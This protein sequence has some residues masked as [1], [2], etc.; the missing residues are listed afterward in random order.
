M[1]AWM[2]YAAALSAALCVAALAAERALRLTGGPTRLAWALAMAASLALPF[3]LPR[4]ADPPLAAVQPIVDPV[5]TDYA[6]G[7]PTVVS[8]EDPS[9][10][11]TESP[12]P[13]SAWT[14]IEAR[15]DGAMP[16]AWGAVSGALLI[17]LAAAGAVLARRRRGWEPAVVSGAAVLLSE[18][19]GPAVVG[20]VDPAIVLPRWTTEWA[21]PLRRLIVRHERE[22]VE[23]GDPRLLLGA[24]VAVAL[25][26]WNP[27]L[28]WQLRRL[29][30]AVEIDCDT[31]TLRREGD[32][33]AYGLLLLEVGR[34][35]AGAPLPVAAFSEPRSFLERRIRV[36]TSRTPR[37][38]AFRLAALALVCAGAA[39]GA[40]ALPA[41]ALPL[42]GGGSGDSAPS[43]DAALASAPGAMSGDTTLPILA[44]VQQLSR[45]IDAQYPPLLRGA[46][47]GGMATV[48]MR[49]AENGQPEDITVVSADRAELGQ[50]ALRAMASARF[51]PA[52]VEGRAVPYRLTL[53]VTFQPEGGD[54]PPAL[55]RGR[56]EADTV[57]VVA[58]ESVDE[59]PRIVNAEQ[60]ARTFERLYPPML[61]EA[62]ISGQV[63]VRLLVRADGSVAESEVV[64]TTRPELRQPALEAMR[65]LRFR[66]ARRGGRAVPVRIVL[67]FTFRAAP[68]RQAAVRGELERAEAEMAQVHG[69]MERQA[70]V[71]EEQ[72]RRMEGHARE[73]ASARAELDAAAEGGKV[74]R[75]ELERAARELEEAARE[76][77]GRRVEVERAARELEAMAAR[78][79]ER[80]SQME[81]ARRDLEAAAA[82]MAG[83]RE[84][85]KRMER[86]LQV[87]AERM[88]RESEEMRRRIR[89]ELTRRQQGVLQRGT[90][91]DEYVFFI[92][93]EQGRVKESGIGK[94]PAGEVGR[95]WSSNS[96]VE[97]IEARFRGSKVVRTF[98]WSEMELRDGGPTANVAWVTVES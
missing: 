87:E 31:R 36:M 17:A 22:H 93:D 23:A 20:F 72:A 50:A 91:D 1:I 65:E 43:L 10:R 84:E 74:D 3:V 97:Q 62:G 94:I 53:P 92:A 63:T 89:E 5:A 52:R 83:R 82:E 51:Q 69:Q 32:V 57:P 24:L 75:K 13:P 37:N 95:G 15:A 41:P 40:A 98:H 6:I 60:M 81:G 54:P 2:L 71:L 14:A 42:S 19:T 28:W 49:V 48:R 88:R 47:I 64:S 61:R 66:P 26:P 80:R 90:A 18:R 34:R 86:E 4:A 45:A 78:E 12:S 30:L 27:A 33:S 67:P 77:S 79:P 46:G 35:G 96:L 56:F 85:M 58:L 29:R 70:R 9:S 59:L 76:M 55:I 21:E 73:L 38:R 8:I 7:A 39:V 68:A 16:Y 44:N 25:M 11:S